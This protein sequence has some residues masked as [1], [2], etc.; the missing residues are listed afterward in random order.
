[1]STH[2]YALIGLTAIVAALAATLTYAVLRIFGA[3]RDAGGALTDRDRE[4]AW[5]TAAMEDAVAR[6]KR[7][8]QAMAARAAASERLSEAMVASLTS[9]LLV[10]DREGR[11]PIVNPAARRLLALPEPLT[12]GTPYRRLLQQAGPLADVIAECLASGH[13]IVRRTLDFERDGQPMSLG[14]TVSPLHGEGGTPAGAICLFTDLTTVREL[15]DRIRLKES[16]A[17]VGELTAGLAHEF[18]NGLATIHGYSRLLDLDSLPEPYRPYVQAIR[19][20]TE[21]L[22]EV[23][24]NF[25]AF[26]KPAALTLAPVDL[27]AIVERAVEDAQADCRSRGGTIEVCGTFATIDGDEV[28]LRQAFA[29]LLRNALESC[30]AARV[31]PQIVVESVLEA[32][33]RM[34]RVT[35]TDNGAG[36]APADRERIFRPF[37]TTKNEGTG[38]GLAIVQKIVVSHNGRVT[39]AAAPGGGARIEIRMPVLQRDGQ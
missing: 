1:M 9:G 15:E 7:Q 26:A 16:L 29:N 13:A 21:A 17:Q 34:A 23:V 8:E 22:G 10:V 3:A 6:L 4:I 37:F 35:V 14:V 32:D 24:T 5:M 39:A 27:R 31:A 25:L 33:R 11:V 38:L 2:A 12:D 18:R 36:I 30:E 20:E 28:L 19:D